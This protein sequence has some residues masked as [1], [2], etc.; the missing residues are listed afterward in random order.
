MLIDWFTVIAQIANF[1]ILVWLMKR[2]LYKPVLQ[3]IDQREEGI[4]GQIAAA[5]N[6]K[7][8]AKKL[9]EL[10][11][12]KNDDFDRQFSERMAAA[13]T[14]IEAKRQQWL[15]EA[16]TAAETLAEQRK[17][18]LKKDAQDFE[19][20]FHRQTRETV[21]SILKKIL[22]DLAGT[23]FEERIAA[24]MLE[25]LA[26]PETAESWQMQLSDDT[27]GPVLVTSSFP[28]S[29]T[30]KEQF[31]LAIRAILPAAVQISFDQDPALICGIEIRFSDLKIA[32]NVQDYLDALQKLMKVMVDSV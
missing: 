21:I 22:Q 19:E 28:L 25:R 14:E 7:L 6:E 24:V 20:D 3:A 10:F 13:A 4:A 9:R 2:F 23:N 12:E 1:L 11:T 26:L 15:A 27:H 32:W 17:A 18:L 8:E 16:R 31:G 29:A 5:E 30:H